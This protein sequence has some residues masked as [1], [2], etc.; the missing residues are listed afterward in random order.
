M[1]TIICSGREWDDRDRYGR[2]GRDD[3]RDDWRDNSSN[4]LRDDRRDSNYR[5][6][7]NSYRDDRR[8]KNYRNESAQKRDEPV[9]H[10]GVEQ[11]RN[12]RDILNG[13]SSTRVAQ[14]PGGNSSMGSLIYGGSSENNDR[15]PL[16]ESSAR[17]DREAPR[18]ERR[19]SV[20]EWERDQPRDRSDYNNY[21][22]SRT[23]NSRDG[24]NF[25]PP[26]SANRNNRDDTISPQRKGRGQELTCLCVSI[27]FSLYVCVYMSL[28]DACIPFF[29]V[30][31]CMWT[32]RVYEPL[33]GF[34][35]F[36][37]F[38]L[39]TFVPQKISWV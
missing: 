31:I 20:R 6:R 15:R 26:D 19:D 3:R 37:I 5:D 32:D 22:N 25:G 39:S 9:R 13:H 36:M 14:A 28:S 2:E 1:Q 34:N 33:S 21:S 38:D 16:R 8:D 18:D 27:F 23:S 17:R 10:G 12:D 4:E 30:P 7:D 11:R 35:N 29:H 24:Q